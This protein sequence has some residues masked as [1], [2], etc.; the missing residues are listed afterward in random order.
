M[1]QNISS[2]LKLYINLT[3]RLTTDQLSIVLQRRL[4]FIYKIKRF[5]SINPSVKISQI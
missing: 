3:F 5:K 2:E 4:T 1:I